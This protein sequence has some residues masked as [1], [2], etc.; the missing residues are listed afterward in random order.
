MRCLLLIWSMAMLAGVSTL[1][2]DVHENLKAPGIPT[3]ALG[4][5]VRTNLKVCVPMFSEC[6]IDAK[7]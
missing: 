7:V 4:L 2:G 6:V 3:N 5:Y 1:T